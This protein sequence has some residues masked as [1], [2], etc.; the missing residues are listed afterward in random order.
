MVSL[1]IIAAVACL[2]QAPTH[3]DSPLLGPSRSPTTP[4]TQVPTQEPRAPAPEGET[5]ESSTPASETPP[6]SEMPPISEPEPAAPTSEPAA[7]ETADTSETPKTIM[8]EDP[9]GPAE[10][11]S[12]TPL[13]APAEAFSRSGGLIGA[14]AGITNC[15]QSDCFDIAMAGLGRL[16]LGYRIGVAALVASGSVGGASLSAPAQYPGLKGRALFVD[17]GGGIQISPVRKGRV[18]P[19][20]GAKLGYTQMRWSLTNGIE[21]GKAWYSR[22]FV[23]FTTGLNF[24]VAKV[25]AIGP[26]FDYLIPFAGKLCSRDPTMSSCNSTKDLVDQGQDAYERRSIRRTFAQPWSLTVNLHFVLG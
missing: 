9:T 8:F 7:A 3:R 15:S 18:D 4:P 5:S 11:R 19:F 22:G 6:A 23:G 13:E 12:Q 10:L 26:R 25:V 24:F 21:D 2:V 20:I 1:Q 16:E 14:S 17:I